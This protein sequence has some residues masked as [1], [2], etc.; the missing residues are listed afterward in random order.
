[1]LDAKCYVALSGA[2]AAFPGSVR[3]SVPGRAA[4]AAAGWRDGGRVPEAV[5][6]SVSQCLIGRKALLYFIYGPTQLQFFSFS[7]SLIINVIGIHI[8]VSEQDTSMLV[9]IP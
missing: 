2:P 3:T 7:S 4:S 9:Q 6:H 5:N 8:R 1:M